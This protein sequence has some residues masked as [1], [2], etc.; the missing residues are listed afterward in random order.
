MP[1]Q[2]VIGG[3]WQV[4][5]G[6]RQ[7]PAAAFLAVLVFLLSSCGDGGGGSG[8]GS[9]TSATTGPT[10]S[11]ADTGESVVDPR[12]VPRTGFTDRQREDLES[13]GLSARKLKALEE[14][15][16]RLRAEGAFDAPPSKQHRE[17]ATG[18]AS[19]EVKG[20]DNSIQQFG[21]EATSSELGQ[22]ALALHGY[23]DARAAGEWTT[24]CSYLADGLAGSMQQLAGTGGQG[25]KAPS[26]AEV[27]ASL[28]A[29]L[30]PQ[31]LSESA[32]ADV[33]ALR[34]QGD[35]GYLLFHGAEGSDYFIPMASQGG[36]WRVAAVAPSALG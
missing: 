9:T 17:S 23:L 6:L 10:A 8:T 19:F 15:A 29:G 5:R 28:S 34:A 4:M 30:P 35:R 27:L 20:G 3:R 2:R 16:T 1:R 13:R 18:A 11:K 24:A 14:K 36:E 31:L 22:A 33:G 21:S 25:A 26:C 12:E 7:A 32:I